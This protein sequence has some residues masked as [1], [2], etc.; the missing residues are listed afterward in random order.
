MLFACG[1]ETTEQTTESLENSE[2][3]SIDIETSEQKIGYMVGYQEASM[4]VQNGMGDVMDNDAFVAGFL[5]AMNG[6]SLKVDPEEAMALLRAKQMEPFEQSKKDGENFLA[7]NS[8]REEVTTLLSGL[9]YEVVEEGNG[10]KP[11]YLDKVK[12]H[13]RLSMID[14]TVL[15]SSF[16]SGEPREF[17]V[18]RLI[19]GWTEALQLMPTGSTWKLYIPYQL[20]YG[21]NGNENI[22]PYTTLVFDVQLLEIVK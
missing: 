5:D 12:V 13:Y 16:E 7:E 14:G 15:Q 6:D 1:G 21:E 10:P 4:M 9:Q 17:E 22:P 8:K 19:P 18:S 20:G 2:A 11:E 3:A